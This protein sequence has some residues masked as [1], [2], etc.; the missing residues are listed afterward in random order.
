MREL[1][2]L[3]ELMRT[4]GDILFYSEHRD[5]YSY[6]EG[7]I[8]ELEVPFKY[9]TS[10]PK[11]PHG[12]YLNKL[13]PFWMLVANC[14]VFIMTMPDLGKFHL[15]KSIYPVHYVYMFHH[16]NSTH[17]TDRL[18]AFDN[19]NSILCCGPHQ[20]EE[21][22]KHEIHYKLS[23]KI[24]VESG[25]YRLEKLYREY[26]KY[27]RR[28][29]NS[30]I[31]I[32]PSWGKGNIVETCGS[33][34]VGRLLRE[35]YKVILRPHIE[36]T[37]HYPKLL[38]T[39]DQFRDMNFT[40]EESNSSHSSLLEADLL[41]T[42]YSGIGLKYALGTERPVLFLD[43]P[44]KVRNPQW[45]ELNLIPVELSLRS[46]IGILLPPNDMDTILQSVRLLLA[47][48]ANYKSKLVEIRNKYIFNFG[49]AS[50]I[51]AKYIRSLL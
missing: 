29:E 24:L 31:L 41:I 6:F 14:K 3:R 23:S 37:K 26:Q 36:T 19:Y 48:K 47:D 10:D 21:I 44:L 2:N 43:A 50:K 15:R 1:Q 51:E 49:Q 20:I 27:T 34:L 46:E 11:D 32:A 22:R 8:D 17:M 39:F 9:I 42:D 16:M 7:L 12:F 30:T 33:R 25:Y 4:P 5:Y 13:L 35:G 40:L 28:G 38:K 45:K 18:G